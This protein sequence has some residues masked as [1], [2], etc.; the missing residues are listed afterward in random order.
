MSLQ[1]GQMHLHCFLP[2][3][4]LWMKGGSY[5]LQL[6]VQMSEGLFHELCDL[7]VSSVEFLLLGFNETINISST[8]GE[9]L[10]DFF[11]CL[12]FHFGQLFNACCSGCQDVLYLSSLLGLL[13]ELDMPC[14]A[15]WA[16]RLYALWG[17][18][19]VCNRVFAMGR[20]SYC[21]EPWSCRALQWT[22]VV[23]V[24]PVSHLR[25]EHV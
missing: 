13:V 11:W 14:D 9:S 21:H 22:H 16:Q 4:L 12:V 17:F 19:N 6:L 20:A 10:L 25:V 5:Y 8:A 2:F 7:L 3:L 24:A 23:P 1:W 15:L 18:A